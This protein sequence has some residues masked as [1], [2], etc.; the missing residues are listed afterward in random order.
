[1]GEMRESWF[2]QALDEMKETKD[3][4]AHRNSPYDSNVEWNAVT[5]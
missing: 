4:R 1:M 2:L 3:N 5:P